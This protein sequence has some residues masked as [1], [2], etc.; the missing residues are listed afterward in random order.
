MSSCL[1]QSLVLLLS[2]SSILLQHSHVVAQVT[3]AERQAF[4]DGHN[5]VRRMVDP[6]ACPPLPP[7]VWHD[8]LAELAQ[9]YSEKCTFTHNSQRVMA[10]KGIF[11][12]VG[13]NLYQGL[14]LHSSM[15]AGVMEVENV[16]ETWIMEEMFYNYTTNTCSNVCGHYTQVVWRNTT[17]IG[18]GITN[19][20]S[21]DRYIVVCNYGEAGNFVGQS[22]YQ[23]G[24]C[25]LPTTPPP[26]TTSPPPATTSPPPA[27][28]SQSSGVSL[29][30]ITSSL[31]S[32]LLASLLTVALV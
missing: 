5:N 9:N 10:V 8:A 20:T 24:S 12:S 13:E 18:C 29:H 16:T 17:Y 23:T 31:I 32:V 15:N 3:S 19:C 6:R 26:A 7:L 22:P 25:P 2:V 30:S 14:G 28:I 1:A 21:P 27:P 4:L 11:S